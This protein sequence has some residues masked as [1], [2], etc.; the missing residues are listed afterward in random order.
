METEAFSVKVMNVTRSKAA[1]ELFNQD[2]ND[3]ETG[4]RTQ[5]IKVLGDGWMG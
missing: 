2:N 4:G 5:Q 3:K 1:E